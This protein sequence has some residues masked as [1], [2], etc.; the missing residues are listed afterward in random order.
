MSAS[1]ESNFEDF[2]IEQI[3]NLLDK[4]YFD[5]NPKHNCNS[6]ANNLN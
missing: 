3:A 5:T 4:T 6:K 1:G 2:L